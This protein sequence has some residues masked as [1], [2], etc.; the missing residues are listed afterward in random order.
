MSGEACP[1]QS[2]VDVKQTLRIATVNVASGTASGRRLRREG[3][4]SGEFL[5]ATPH[6][7]IGDP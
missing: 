1:R 2:G 4:G 5:A 6:P 7:D 3:Q